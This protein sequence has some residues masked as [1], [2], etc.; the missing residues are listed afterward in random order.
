VSI[1][2]ITLQNIKFGA[3][4][5]RSYKRR[6]NPFDPRLPSHRVL[7]HNIVTE[8]WLT[9][10]TFLWILL[11]ELEEMQATWGSI[12]IIKGIQTAK[13]CTLPSYW[14]WHSTHWCCLF[15]NYLSILNTT[16]SFVIVL[17]SCNTCLRKNATS[18][19]ASLSNLE[20]PLQKECESGLF[21]T[22]TCCWWEE[23]N[24]ILKTTCCIQMTLPLSVS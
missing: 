7:T 23:F 17:K 20:P 6:Y 8:Y 3:D 15:H 22:T 4:N 2:E 19:F 11:W 18:S 5:I 14:F 24:E 21:L 13:R 12:K 10:K 9:P 1:D 16:V